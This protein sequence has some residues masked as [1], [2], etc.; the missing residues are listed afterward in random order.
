MFSEW[1]LSFCRFPHKWINKSL[2]CVDSV[3]YKS[4]TLSILKLLLWQMNSNKL[5]SSN[6][7]WDFQG[8]PVV[9]TRGLLL[10]GAQVQF[11]LGELRSLMPCGSS[12]YNNNNNKKCSTKRLWWAVQILADILGFFFFFFCLLRLW[13]CLAELYNTHL[14]HS[15]K[16][17][18]QLVEDI[19]SPTV[20][21]I[22]FVLTA[23]L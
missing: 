23:Q 12:N 13:F 21:P 18:F 11:L 5:F 7:L 14:V 1:T 19:W 8:G 3:H 17:L 2:T 16:I 22:R 6:K 9:K 15:L 10:Q 20:P 4:H